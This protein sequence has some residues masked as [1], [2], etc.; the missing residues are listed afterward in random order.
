MHSG[1]EAFEILAAYAVHDRFGKD[2]PR[3]VAL[4]Q[5]E[6][7]VVTEGSF[8]LVQQSV[9]RAGSRRRFAPKIN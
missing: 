9:G 1:A 4:G 5:K 3:S 8:R 6:D 2:A 7:V